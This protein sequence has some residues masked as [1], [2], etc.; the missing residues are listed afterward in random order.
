MTTRQFETLRDLIY[1]SLGLHFED[2]KLDFLDKRVAKR[3]DV[4]GM[5]RS[6][7]YVFHLRFCDPEGLEMQAL[8]NLVTTNETYMFREFEQLQAFADH[9]L[10]EAIE[11]RE[12]SGVRRLRIWS[13]GCASGEEAYSLA[14]IL[15]EVMHDASEW[16]LRILATD[17]DEVRLGMAQRAV[18][19]PYATREV[20]DE[21]ASRH[22]IR[23]GPEEHKIHPDTARLVELRH[24]NLS[25]RHAMR[26]IR[27]VDFVFCRNVLIYFDDA[28]RK[29]VVDHFYNSLNPGGFLYLGHAESVSRISAAF[30]MARLGP[31]LVYRKESQA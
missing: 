31:H 3:M 9:C 22:L 30:K 12:K 13:A 14:I 6:E 16:D 19:G 15:R 29:S 5:T 8:A 28:S 1:K 18:Y 27:D 10:P 21:Y 2:A 17:L 24:L 25:D 11:R 20:P 7:D 23:V 4:L 26:T